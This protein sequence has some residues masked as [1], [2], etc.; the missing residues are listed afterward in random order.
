M[1]SAA[2]NRALVAAEDAVR[3]ARVALRDA[4]A[5]RADADVKIQRATEDLALADGAY[6]QLLED[7]LNG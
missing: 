3:N 1:N 7:R 2:D 4:N 6:R 5:E